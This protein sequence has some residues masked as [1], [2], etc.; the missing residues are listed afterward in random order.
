LSS[1]S[2]QT[3]F[4]AL[5]FDFG[6]VKI[7]VASGQ[8]L[9][10]TAQALAPL[11]AR[12]GT[13]QWEQ[14]EAL[15]KEWQPQVLVVGL[16]LNMDDTDNNIT[17]RARRFANRLTGRFNIPHVLWDERLSTREAKE[18][19][20]EHGHRGNFRESPVDSFAAQ[21]ILESWFNAGNPGLIIKS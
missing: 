17:V 20:F 14:V 4:T 21:L 19:A 12:D 10:G 1:P 16:P 2:K 11:K 15:L 13:P 6:L 8:S 5:A 9:L 18:I 7:G 3:T